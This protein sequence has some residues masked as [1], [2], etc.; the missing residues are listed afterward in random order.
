LDWREHP[1]LALSGLIVVAAALLLLV[2]RGCGCGRSATAA[3][4]KPSETAAGKTKTPAG[5]S[6]PKKEWMDD[7]PEPPNWGKEDETPKPA[8]VAAKPPPLPLPRA[9]RASDDDDEAA[10]PSRVKKPVR[11]NDVADWKRDDYYSA[12]RDGD[13]R[14]TAA[15]AW[16]GERFAGHQSAAELLTRLLELG[17]DDPFGETAR[18][19]APAPDPKLTEAIVAALAVNGTPLATETLQRLVAG[20]LSTADNQLAAVAALKA[21]S[22]R[23]QRERDDLLFRVVTASPPSAEA[24]RPT[25]DPQKLRATALELVKSRASEPLRL[26]LAQY[27]VEPQTPQPLCD[28]LWDCLKEPRTENLA[29]QIVFYRSDR[30]D[31]KTRQSLEEQFT[32][33]SATALG[34]LLGVPSANDR[35]PASDV[36]AAATD[37]YR[38]AELLWGDDFA[39]TVAARL[40]TVDGLAHG[41]RL[42][43]LA[44][45]IPSQTMRV[46]LVQTL[47]KYWEDGPRGLETPA[48]GDGAFQEPGFL[49]VLKKL[50][51]RDVAPLAARA[52]KQRGEGA[53]QSSAKAAKFAAARKAKQRQDELSQQWMTYSENLVQATCRRLYAAAV[54]PAAAGG[55][56]KA[57]D[58]ADLP[59][60]P[61]P[62]AEVAASYRVNWPADLTGRSPGPAIS[63]LRVCYVRIEQRARPAALLA[64]YRRQLPNCNEHGD[65]HGIW[66]DAFATDKQRGAA[67]SLDVL[68]TK[69]N[70]DAPLVPGEEQ[71]LIVEILSVEVESV[72]HASSDAVTSRGT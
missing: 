53:A 59:L 16:L 71:Q 41:G 5:K 66:L 58:A 62:N 44:A 25:I 3:A 4:A 37:S 30:L 26:R 36:A 48:P 42:L 57:E 35:R 43:R 47:N 10:P 33:Q 51:H 6:K 15:V 20:K 38:A 56:P 8:A 14:L 7:C 1:R 21:L 63:P 12:K 18:R 67:R 9:K 61:H 28:Q 31:E 19:R 50:P 23:S 55:R 32:L 27:A 60:K 49:L 24:D 2:A 65:Q 22:G 52:P 45:A 70:K 17:A 29:S 72:R 34:R 54:T 69:S 11:P 46:A 64:Y 13:P 39:A 40:R 68:I